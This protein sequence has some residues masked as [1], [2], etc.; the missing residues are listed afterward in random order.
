VS[1]IVSKIYDRF[2]ASAEREVLGDWRRELLATAKGRV[3]EV[4]AGT[5]LNL[6]YYSKSVT[7]VT[8]VEPDRH[9]RAQL[10]RRIEQAPNPGVR[11]VDARAEQLPFSDDSFDTVVATLVLCSVDDVE[12]ALQ[13]FRR[14]LKPGG[15]FLFVEHVAAREHSGRLAWQRRL[16]PVWKR[17][18][19]NCHLT[20]RPADAMR[21][22]GF[23][24]VDLTRESMGKGL[25]ILRPTIRGEARLVF[26][27]PG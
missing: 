19:D 1:W 3:L 25:P 13:E 27:P 6:K 8:A 17:V 10:A 9:M 22:A 26:N 12:A 4:G 23:E 15:R 5:G 14:V 2:M 16:E 11:L 24:L 7:D 21:E 18:A 20:R